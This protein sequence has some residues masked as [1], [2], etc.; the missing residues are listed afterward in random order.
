MEIM[1]SVVSEE[2]V[3]RKIRFD[4]M[5]PTAELNL[6]MLD[7]V[8]GIFSHLKGKEFS[9]KE[10]LQNVADMISKHLRIREVTIGLRSPADG[11]FRYE[12][13]TG[14]RDETWE[15]HKVLVF[16]DNQFFDDETYKGKPLTK[17]TKLFLAE[18][19]PYAEGEEATYSR[20]VMLQSTRYNPDDSIE[21]DYLDVMIP[22]IED[23]WIGWIETS[24]TRTGKLPDAATIRW[25][26]LIAH[27]VGAI[28]VARGPPVT[29]K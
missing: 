16:D 18:T 11:L 23:H 2:E 1:V 9:A 29:P 13:M 21:G 5:R 10:L 27:I 7:D 24:G 25:L 26:E 20:P 12:V 4:F 6:R 19:N 3:L 17:Y 28:L 22:G 8:E 14:L 15:V